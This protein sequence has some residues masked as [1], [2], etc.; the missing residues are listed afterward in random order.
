MRPKT[1]CL[2]NDRVASLRGA[3]GEART[4]HLFGE[5]RITRQL[6]KRRTRLADCR[7]DIFGVPIRLRYLFHRAQV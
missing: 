5:A 1:K 4:E 3:A 7:L 6:G 2:G